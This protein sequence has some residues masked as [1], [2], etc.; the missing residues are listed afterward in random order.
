MSQTTYADPKTLEIL[1]YTPEQ[2]AYTYGGTMFGYINDVLRGVYEPLTEA[3]GETA[4]IEVEHMSRGIDSLMERAGMPM[5]LWRGDSV[6]ELPHVG[7]VFQDLAYVSTS[8]VRDVAEKFVQARRASGALWQIEAGDDALCI[9]MAAL[10]AKL[11]PES[12][13]LARD[14]QEIL[15]AR[16][17][18]WRVEQVDASGAFP[19]IRARLM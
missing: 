14:E 2:C 6:L 7:Q 4:R 12:S 13:G 19:V 8:L 18:S 9:D 3:H 5:T 17:S 11:Y 16:G 10:G 15:L 1:S